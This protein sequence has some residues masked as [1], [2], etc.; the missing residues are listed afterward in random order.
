MQWYSGGIVVVVC[1]FALSLFVYI[2]RL[3]KKKLSWNDFAKF[4]EVP[5]CVLVLYMDRKSNAPNPTVEQ[6]R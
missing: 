2:T 6:R 1:F 3:Q 5:F 4:F